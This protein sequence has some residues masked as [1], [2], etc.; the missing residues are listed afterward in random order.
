M[1]HAIFTGIAV[2]NLR[3]GLSRRAAF[4][5]LFCRVREAS[6]SQAVLDLPTWRSPLTLRI[7]GVRV[8]LQ[9]RNMPTVSSFEA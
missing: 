4:A 1:F 6:L 9:Q 5:H 7:T 3:L 2:H 8:E